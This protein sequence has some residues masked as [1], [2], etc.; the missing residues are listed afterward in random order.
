MTTTTS[1]WMAFPAEKWESLRC[2]QQQSNRQHHTVKLI[3]LIRHAEGTHNVN[4]DYKSEQNIDAR[5]TAR[6]MN[7]C[8]AFAARTV[9]EA[10]CLVT[11]PLTRCV[12]TAI[13]ACPHL[14]QDPS[15]SVYANDAWRET[16]NY[17]CDR[18]RT[19]QEIQS[20]FPQ[21]DFHS[22]PTENEDTLWEHYRI[23]LGHNWDTH[24]ESAELGRVAHRGRIALDDLQQRPEARIVVCTHSALLRCI[25]NWGHEGG[26]P[27]MVP[28][29]NLS[30]DCPD[31]MPMTKLL[32]YAEEQVT[33]HEGRL[34]SFESFMRRDFENCEVRSFC[35]ANVENAI[36]TTT[37]NTGD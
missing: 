8:Q 33:D 16:V 6:G 12:Q 2:Q 19:I 27:K 3:H 22:V 17:N 23:R 24:M 11:S 14:L 1:P 10:D 26:V 7:Q 29:Q 15:V 35:L 4:G 5:L 34:C 9:L 20:E 37:T 36:T 21:V 30:D 28:Q 25:L 13:H 32:L 31:D 18:R